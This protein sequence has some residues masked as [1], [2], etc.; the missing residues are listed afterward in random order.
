MTGPEAS[1]LRSLRALVLLWL[2]AVSAAWAGPAVRSVGVTVDDLDRSVA[3]FADVLDFDHARIGWVME[4]RHSELTCGEC[5]DKGSV[6][7]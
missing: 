1:M 6:I 3:F 4:G 2:V 5:H 7:C